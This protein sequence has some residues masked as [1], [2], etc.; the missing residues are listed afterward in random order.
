MARLSW[1]DDTLA[2]VDKLRPPPAAFAA[3]YTRWPAGELIAGVS[4]VCDYRAEEEWGVAKPRRTITSDD[5]RRF[6]MTADARRHIS[7]CTT[8]NAVALRA[9]GPLPKT[10]AWGDVLGEDYASFYQS[11]LDGVQ[12]RDMYRLNWLTVPQLRAEVKHLGVTPLPRTKAALLD[13]L[14]QHVEPTFPDVWPGWFHYGDLLVLRADSGVSARALQRV[15]AAVETA[16]LGIGSGSGPFHSGLF[17]Y[18]TTDETAELVAE[19]TRA[20]D[21][22]DERMAALGTLEH[23]LRAEMGAKREHLYFLGEPTEFGGEVRYWMNASNMYGW[24]SLDELRRRD[25]DACRRR[26]LASAPADEVAE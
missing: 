21:L 26:R 10:F 12:G 11:T 13:V 15:R 16:T 1:D 14:R 6:Q 25:F 24:F 23:D 9:D 8:A 19:R 18:D 22:H 5:P 4:Y 3:S 7:L 20:F 2:A 17:F